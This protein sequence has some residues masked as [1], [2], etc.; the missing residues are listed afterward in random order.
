MRKD[1]TSVVEPTFGGVYIKIKLF[2]ED[3]KNF[4]IDIIFVN[5]L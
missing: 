4:S 1:E 5:I 3:E 2:K